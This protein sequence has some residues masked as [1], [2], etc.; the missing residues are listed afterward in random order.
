MAQAAHHPDATVPETRGSGRALA[1]RGSLWTFIGYGGSQV[2]RL[3]SNLVLAWL[4]FPGAFGLM[5][6]V[7]V[8][9]HGMQMFSDLGL[10]AN[11]IR[12]ARGRE[13]AFLNTAWTL[14]IIRGV[15]L[16]L[17]ASALAFPVAG[18]F[19]ASDPAAAS[20][21]TLLPVAA[22]VALIGGFNSTGIFLFN[23]G[24]DLRRLTGLEL[25]SQ[26]V[27]VL[28]MIA[29]A[30]LSPTVWAL[31]AGN[32]AASVA[33][34]ILSH[35]W[36]PGPANRLAWDRSCLDEMFH[37]GK[38]VFLSTLVAFLAGNLDRILLGKT[39]SLAE[40]G[41]YSIAMTFA[42]VGIHVSS[43]LGS[44]VIFPLLS[45]LQDDPARLVDA[46]LR[47]RQPVLW[48]SGAVCVGFALVAPLFFTALYDPRY[49]GAGAIAQWLALY[50]WSHVLNAT[51]D[52]IPLSLG[53]P[54]LLFS[55][56]LLTTAGTFMAVPGFALAGLPG[57]ILGMVCANLL[58]HA[59]LV[60][61]LPLGR[62]R[63]WRQDVGFTLGLLLYAAPCL[64]LLHAAPFAASPD[65]HALGVLLAVLPLAGLGAWKIWRAVRA[66]V[67]MR[68][69]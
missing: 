4:L 45:R 60:S 27:A 16:W 1:L 40:L 53:Q 29:W 58:A 68:V 15:S 62:E 67:Q 8:F 47:A 44:T 3:G 37:F 31:V 49:A 69:A 66:P 61:R 50:V 12:H 20:L 43:R 7:N 10:G 26:L 11:I 51:M 56:N 2:L 13:P 33:R 23:R 30:L 42:R 6:L 9:M 41:V 17:I 55:A 19:A 28:V 57:F 46:C 59:Y 63:M 48:L 64:A 39:L 35:A 22:L 25:I 65:A 54:R 32:L 52:R 5:A 24:M 38:W 18:F 34:L 14:Q 21:S 36:N